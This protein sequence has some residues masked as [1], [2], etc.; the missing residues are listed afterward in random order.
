VLCSIT[1][2]TIITSFRSA[3]NVDYFRQPFEYPSFLPRAQKSGTVGPGF[4]SSTI[5]WVSLTVIDTVARLRGIR[6]NT[7]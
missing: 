5:T 4:K 2:L 1:I 3:G 6:S 7:P